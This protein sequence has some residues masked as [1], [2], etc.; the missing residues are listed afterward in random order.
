MICYYWPPSGGPGSLRALKFA[1]YLPQFG[2]RPVIMTVQKGEFPY[3]DSS[4]AEDL[5]TKTRIYRTKSW[6]P[7]ILYKKMTQ[8][9][10]DDTLPVG[11]L[12]LEKQNARERIA[13]WIRANL[14]VPDGRIG[15]IPFAVREGLKIIKKEKID[16]IFTSSPPHSLQLIGLMLKKMTHLPW[17]AD[18]RDPWTDIR[19]Y[20]SIKRNA[21]I[22]KIDRSLETKVLNEADHVLT[23]SHSLASDFQNSRMIQNKKKVSIFPNGYD[24]EEFKKRKRPAKFQITHTGNLL[25]HQN[26]EV[27]WKS[28]SRLL[29]EIPD[30]KDHLLIRFIGRIHPSILQSALHFGLTSY[31]ESGPF[32]PHKVIVREMVASSILMVVIPDTENNRGI[33]T[34]KLFEYI[35]SGNPILLIA[36]P[37]GDAAKIISEMTN[38]TV[39]NYDNTEC[40]TEFIQNMYR[41]WKKDKL[42][43]SKDKK[44]HHYSRKEIT[45]KLANLFFTLQSEQTG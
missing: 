34:A 22:D 39:C 11:I 32:L 7:F 31:L 27:L 36:P 17:I 14:F 38:S 2:W 37:N 5:F 1:R 41:A 45:K 35:G 23:V 20:R 24:E 8:R 9:K 6:E 29:Q 4:L 28:V 40:C 15:W 19:Y 43:I 16:F 21:C 18:L 44:S 26:P 13:A 33:V 25:E 30:F 42:P 3:I 10:E 12:T